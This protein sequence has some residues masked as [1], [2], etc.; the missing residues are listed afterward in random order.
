ML[1]YVD[2]L[3]HLAKNAQE[4]TLKLNQ[5]YGPKEGFGPPDRYLVAN[6]D[7]V[8][9]EDGI[10][11]WYMT[12]IEYLCGAINN[13]YSILE[14]NKASP[15]SFEDGYITYPSSY[16]PELEVTNELDE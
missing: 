14:G 9:L 5:D 15:K 12:F 8:Q 16:R 11:V 2:D 6:M 4:Y 3:I 13:V 7:K 1:V 10:T